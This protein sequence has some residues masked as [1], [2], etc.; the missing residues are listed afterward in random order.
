MPAAISLPS[1]LSNLAAIIDKV[2]GK[3][4]AA[5]IGEF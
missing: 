1:T 2:D 3:D 4:I 5:G